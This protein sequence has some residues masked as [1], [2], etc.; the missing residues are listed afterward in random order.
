M[1]QS[2]KTIGILIQHR[3]VCCYHIPDRGERGASGSTRTIPVH[4]FVP[5]AATWFWLFGIS[6]ECKFFL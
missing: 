3:T 6:S 5:G 4:T 2:L 1:K